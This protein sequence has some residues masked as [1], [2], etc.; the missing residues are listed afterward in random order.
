VKTEPKTNPE[1][2]RLLSQAARN[3]D[4]DP[5]A[6]VRRAW[7]AYLDAHPGMREHLEDLQLRAQLEHLRNSGLMARA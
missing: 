4:T 1:W 3:C 2:E 7:L 6:F 5:D